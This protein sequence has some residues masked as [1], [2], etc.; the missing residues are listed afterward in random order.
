M[1][2]LRVK[3]VSTAV[4]SV[5]KEDYKDQWQETQEEE[6]NVEEGEDAGEPSDEFVLDRYTEEL[7]EGDV[8]L[9]DL[10]G[11]LDVTFA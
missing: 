10:D 4:V 1:A 2:H 7:A 8:S 9:D 3:V 11:A 5:N 6:G